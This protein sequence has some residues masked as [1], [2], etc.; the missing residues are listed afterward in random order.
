MVASVTPEDISE[1]LND[2]QIHGIDEENR[3]TPQGDENLVY[4]S[5]EDIEHC[6]MVAGDETGDH[7]LAGWITA[8]PEG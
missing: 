3:V 4:R 7:R 5:E 6:T 8:A 2:V 1:L